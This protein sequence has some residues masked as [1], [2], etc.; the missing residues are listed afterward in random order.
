MSYV[1]KPTNKR[2]F[3]PKALGEYITMGELGQVLG[4]TKSG[5]YKLVRRRQI[6][7]ITVGNTLMIRRRDI[8]KQRTNHPVPG[9]GATHEEHT[10]RHLRDGKQE[11]DAAKNT[12]LARSTA[13]II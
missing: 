7:T 8:P 11:R 5:A 1:L 13:D 10:T 3:V 2:Q 4:L 9:R 6:E 12:L